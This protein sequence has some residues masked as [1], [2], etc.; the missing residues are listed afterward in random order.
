MVELKPIIPQTPPVWGRQTAELNAPG[1][2][3]KEMQT[4]NRSESNNSRQQWRS[5]KLRRFKDSQT[6]VRINYANL[7]AAIAP[8][9][10]H[11]AKLK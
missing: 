10:A 5:I 3:S 11:Q 1:C 9:L 7:L 4:D 8:L 2:S 6:G